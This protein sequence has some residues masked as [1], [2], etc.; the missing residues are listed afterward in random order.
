MVIDLLGCRIPG[1]VQ[2]HRMPPPDA[3]VPLPGDQRDVVV[4][5]LVCGAPAN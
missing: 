1:I 2:G 5:W 4:T 3:P